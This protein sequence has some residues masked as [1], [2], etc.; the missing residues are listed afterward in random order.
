L[1]RNGRNEFVFGSR[2]LSK[3]DFENGG[4]DNENETGLFR[5]QHGEQEESIQ[6]RK[7]IK[8]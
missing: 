7:K 8:E 4:S 5:E 2:T 3:R 1:I 6:T